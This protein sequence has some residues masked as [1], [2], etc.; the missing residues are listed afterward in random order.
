ML[1]RLEQLLVN[2]E[3]ESV[4][5]ETDE[6]IESQP[7]LVRDAKDIHVALAAIHAKVDYLV[8]QDKDLTNPAAPIHQQIKLSLPG[9]FCGN[10]WVGQARH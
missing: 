1:G 4:A 5:D 9:R 7:G 2:S 3:Y 8:T 6:A 10:T